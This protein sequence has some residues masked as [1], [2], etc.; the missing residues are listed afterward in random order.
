MRT[1]LIVIL[2]V[3]I[4]VEVW[5]GCVVNKSYVKENAE[6]R[7]KEVGFTIVGYEGWQWGTWLGGKLGG[8]NVWYQLKTI[9]ENGIRYTG[10]LKRWGDEI[11][12][13]GPEAVDAIKP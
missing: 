8:P 3:V 5:A 13:Y 4:V 7:W 12:V 1:V 6:Q 2:S 11:H 10:Y 9:P